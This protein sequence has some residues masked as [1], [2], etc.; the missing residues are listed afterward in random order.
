M[1]M[2]GRYG[3]NGS[4]KKMKMKIVEDEDTCVELMENRFIGGHSTSD[5]RFSG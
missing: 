5:I 2:D 4:V 1:V 3:G